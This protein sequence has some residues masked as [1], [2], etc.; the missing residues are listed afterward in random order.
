MVFIMW[1]TIIINRCSILKMYMWFLIRN[2]GIMWRIYS[3]NFFR[4]STS[5]YLILH[6][7]SVFRI[8]IMHQNRHIANK[9]GIEILNL[10]I[11]NLN[12]FI[13]FFNVW[14]SYKC[15]WTVNKV[16]FIANSKVS[17]SYPTFINNIEWMVCSCIN[18]SAWSV[19]M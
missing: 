3:I 4:S 17:S 9:I 15:C 12:R 1:C 18:V 5:F 13:K 7:I 6:S 19:Q 10:K 2:I 11:I 16:N 8:I 14:T